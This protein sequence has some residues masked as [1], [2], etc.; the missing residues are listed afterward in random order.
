MEIGLGRRIFIHECKDK[1]L[2]RRSNKVL[3]CSRE[4]ARFFS[5]N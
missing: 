2:K 1:A 4:D 5:E 3:F